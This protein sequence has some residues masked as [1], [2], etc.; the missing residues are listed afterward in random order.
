MIETDNAMQSLFPFN[1]TRTHAE[2]THHFWHRV[3]CLN[4]RQY[5]Q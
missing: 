3:S 1:L 5:Q 2:A 4:V